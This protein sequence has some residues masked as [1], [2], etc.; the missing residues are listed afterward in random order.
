M[1]LTAAEKRA[2]TRRGDNRDARTRC[3]LEER[4]RAWRQRLARYASQSLGGDVALARR[5]G[6]ARVQAHRWTQGVR[7]VPDK[8]VPRLIEIVEGGE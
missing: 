6:M 4:D 3:R 2:L 8:W 5:L 7:P 1:I